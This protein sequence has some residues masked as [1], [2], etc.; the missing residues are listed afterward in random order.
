MTII[1]I[2]YIE[3]PLLLIITYNAKSSF[4][5]CHYRDIIHLSMIVLQI[6]KY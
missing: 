1:T 5:G 3:S 2:K 4:L 6:L